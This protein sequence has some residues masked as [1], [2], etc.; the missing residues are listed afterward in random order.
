M[1]FSY[2]LGHLQFFF[3]S[4]CVFFF[5]VAVVSDEINFLI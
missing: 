2:T 5:V 1:T 4:L 3:S